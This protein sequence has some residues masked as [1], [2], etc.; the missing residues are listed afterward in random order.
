MKNQLLA[1]RQTLHNTRC[2]DAHSMVHSLAWRVLKFGG[3]GQQ[4]VQK[5]NPDHYARK[6]QTDI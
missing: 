1:I 2:E 5:R 3:H 6:N 4:P